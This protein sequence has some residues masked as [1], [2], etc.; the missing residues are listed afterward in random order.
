[1]PDDL[2]FE[3]LTLTVND[4]AASVAFYGGRLGLTAA[5]KA[6]IHVE[7]TPTTSRS[8]TGSYEPRSWS[9]TNHPTTNPGNES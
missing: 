4:V 3:G 2:R 7:F 9:F 1:L 6:A 5:Q 8:F